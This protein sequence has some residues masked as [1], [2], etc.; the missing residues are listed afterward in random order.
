MYA[1]EEKEGIPKIHYFF[2]KQKGNTVRE[3]E[4]NPFGLDSIPWTLEVGRTRNSCRTPPCQDLIII[5]DFSKY[6]LPYGISLTVQG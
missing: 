5:V 2:D 4:V 1:R 6:L 3:K